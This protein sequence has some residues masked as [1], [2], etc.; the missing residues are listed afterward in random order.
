MIE[1]KKLLDV[2]KNYLYLKIVYVACTVRLHYRT[3]EEVRG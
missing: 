2:C 1:C 3:S